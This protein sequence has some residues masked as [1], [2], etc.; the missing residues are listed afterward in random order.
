M[1]A[2]VFRALAL[3]ASV[4]ALIGTAGVASACSTGCT[5][6]ITSAQPFVIGVPE[7]LTGT[8]SLAGVPSADKIVITVSG[9]SP[10]VPSATFDSTATN[11]IKF[12]YTFSIPN[13]TF[14]TAGTATVYVKVY[15]GT[16]SWDLPAA[17]CQVDLTTNNLPEVP[18]A[19]G[20]PLILGG[21][22]LL[23]LRRRRN[24]AA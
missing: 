8:I 23:V 2:K 14:G 24:S 11:P 20:L 17:K 12:P 13:E 10:S 18:F 21:G 9:D 3:A 16:S 1:T 22:A 6:T 7:T 19:A 5:T 15:S 4:A